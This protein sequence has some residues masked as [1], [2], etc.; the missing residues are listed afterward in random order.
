VAD[1]MNPISHLV[2]SLYVLSAGVTLLIA[3]QSALV[4]RAGHRSSLFLPFAWLSLCVT[5]DLLSTA[6]VYASQDV[7]E[8]A[9]SFSLLSASPAFNSRLRCEA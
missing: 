7:A 4:S 6:W 9:M 5:L 2:L 8:A 3:L 1:P